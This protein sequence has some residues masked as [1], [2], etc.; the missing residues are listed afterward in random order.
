[1]MAPVTPLAEMFSD[2]DDDDNN[3]DDDVDVDVDMP[4]TSHK[5]PSNSPLASEG[6]KS[7]KMDDDPTPTP[8]VKAAKAEGNIDQIAG[9]ELCHNDEEMLDVGLEDELFLPVYEDEC[10]AEQTEGAGPPQVSAEKLKE[11]DEQDGGD[12]TCDPQP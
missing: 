8:K 2:D 5:H 1:M 11:L 3:D 6:L 9:V 10:I 7:Q 4:A 12:P